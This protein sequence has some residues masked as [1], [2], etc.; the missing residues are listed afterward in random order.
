MPFLKGAPHRL[1]LRTKEK[2]FTYAEFEIEI[3]IAMRYLEKCKIIPQDRI[4][5]RLPASAPFFAFFFA[6][7]RLGAVVT[8]LSIKVPLPKAEWKLLLTEQGTQV[9]DLPPANLPPASLLLFTSGS[10]GAPKLALLTLEQCFASAAA[11]I[12]TLPYQSEDEWLLTLP[13]HH[14]G[15]LG[16]LFRTI[17]AQATL[18]LPRGEAKYTHLSY[19]PT[20]LYR[21]WPTS[22]TLRCLLLGGAPIETIPREL[23]LFASYGLTETASAVL[24]RRHPPHIDSLWFLGFP[25]EHVL[26][27]LGEDG[28]IFVKGSSLFQGYF[29]NGILSPPGEWFGTKDLG[30]FDPKEGFAIL[31]RKDNQ[32]IS[33]GENIQPEEIE[34]A[35]KRHPNVLEAIV[36]PKR[37]PEFGARPVAF[38]HTLQ[39]DL[40][41][42][43]MTRFLADQLPSY[44]I[45]IA[46]FPLQEEFSLSTKIER[47]KVL[48]KNQLLL[49]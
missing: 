11:V 17:L 41:Q 22:K 42:K 31:G 49:N 25:L 28:E 16:I 26:M 3:Q 43:E 38:I 5:I 35:L 32:F 23:P 9:Y 6:A 36:A 1:F 10:S 45:P 46:L 44:K 39:N 8:P 20:Q 21:A 29:E 7:L 47:K 12:R 37:D 13:V 33:G 24:I 14:V 2:N 15:G 48:E 30:R 27:K 34:Q 40:S 18:S 4:G 19:V